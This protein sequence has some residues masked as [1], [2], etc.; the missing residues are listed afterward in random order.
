MIQLPAF[1]NYK[2]FAAFSN[3]G[4]FFI[5]EKVGCKKRR[6]AAEIAAYNLAHHFRSIG[7]TLPNDLQDFIRRLEWY[8][9]RAE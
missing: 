8:S 3:G 6:Q 7:G 9:C 2:S 5:E 4:K 1:Y